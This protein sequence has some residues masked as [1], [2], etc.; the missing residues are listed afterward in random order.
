MTAA[1]SV[2]GA[3]TFLFTLVTVYYAI[4]GPIRAHRAWAI[5]LYA[6]ASSSVF[7][8]VLYFGIYPLIY[9]LWAIPH[10]RNFQAPLDVAFDWLYFLVPM[11]FAEVY[12]R[13]RWRC[14]TPS[15]SAAV[16]HLLV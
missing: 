7:Y 13:V 9:R 16:H 15:P 10:W 2:S 8:R 4:K 3:L 1:F 11:L 14:P 6:L 12:L 5:R